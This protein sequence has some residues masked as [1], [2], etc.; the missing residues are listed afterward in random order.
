[1]GDLGRYVHAIG[2][3]LP[4]GNRPN[5]YA[6]PELAVQPF[7]NGFRHVASVHNMHEQYTGLDLRGDHASAREPQVPDGHG[8]GNGS[9]ECPPVDIRGEWRGQGQRLSRSDDCAGEFGLIHI[10]LEK[11]YRIP[12]T[13]MESNASRF[14][15]TIRS[16]SADVV[17]H[18]YFVLCGFAWIFYVV[19]GI[20]LL[21]CTYLRVLWFRYKVL[22]IRPTSLSNSAIL[23]TYLLLVFLVFLLFSE[24]QKNGKNRGLRV[25]APLQLA[26]AISFAFCSYL[27]GTANLLF[28]LTKTG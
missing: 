5:Y 20:D 28:L 17:F 15:A 10:G 18:Q 3:G 12:K 19:S 27:Q 6:S 24:K 1:M 13:L 21:V 22:D 23:L 8:P 2:R 14:S 9:V 26:F 11:Y 16:G 4:A 25:A 7:R